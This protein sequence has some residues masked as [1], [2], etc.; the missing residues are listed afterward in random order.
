MDLK[1]FLK[2]DKEK[3]ITSVALIII[4]IIFMIFG[5]YFTRSHSSAYLLFFPGMFLLMIYYFYLPVI[6]SMDI[7]YVIAPPPDMDTMTASQFSLHFG[8]MF[9]LSCIYV[10]FITCIVLF[11][12]RNRKVHALKD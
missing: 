12:R 9:L 1:K 8:L 6:L 10:Y 4:S 11:V 2:P 5:I 7:V 3:I